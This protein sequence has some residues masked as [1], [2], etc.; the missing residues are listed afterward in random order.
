MLPLSP[1]ILC[2]SNACRYIYIIYTTYKILNKTQ[3]FVCMTFIVT[4]LLCIEAK[5]LTNR[6]EDFLLSR[7]SKKRGKRKK[8]NAGHIVPCF[9]FAL[10]HWP[11]SATW[12]DE[13]VLLS[14]W[15]GNACEVT[16]TDTLICYCATTSFFSGNSLFV[17]LLFHIG[18]KT[19]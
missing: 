16:T 6:N 14:K 13:V 18:P 17:K 11:L 10:P 12:V 2:K 4:T 19:L 8:K 1:F 9:R 3:Y 5:S 7:W 15:R